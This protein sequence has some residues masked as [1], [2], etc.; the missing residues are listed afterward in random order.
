[1][2]IVDRI[3]EM[4]VD[5]G[6]DPTGGTIEDA[7][8]N[9]QKV[10]GGGSDRIV[11]ETRKIVNDD[12]IEV[13]CNKAFAELVD[14]ITSD[15]L[16]IDLYKASKINANFVTSV[17][18]QG[19]PSADPNDPGQPRRRASIFPAKVRL[20]EPDAGAS[21]LAHYNLVKDSLPINEPLSWSVGNVP[22]NWHVLFL[23]ENSDSGCRIAYNESEHKCCVWVGGGL[24]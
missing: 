6:G 7:L 23:I 14:M 15:G 22:N 10:S 13:Y 18:E 11:V 17:V 2:A 3:N 9:L 12:A 4:T 19:P 21:F 24:E 1:M 8:N 20:P 16:T 5:L